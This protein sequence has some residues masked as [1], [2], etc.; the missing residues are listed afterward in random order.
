MGPGHLVGA[1]ARADRCGVDTS[2]ALAMTESRMAG[3]S[4][5]PRFNIVGFTGHRQLEHP[6]RPGE[7]IRAALD[8][9]QGE[10]SGEWIAVSSAA[11]GAD[12]LFARTSLDA[13][14]AWQA[15]L[16]VPADEFREDFAPEDW[17]TVES[18]LERAETVRV[19]PEAESR[20]DAYLDAGM[21][22]V[23]ECDV[24]VAV[25]DGQPS[26][27]KGGTADV[28]TYARE[29]Q[30][31]VVI[32]DPVSG[33]A[34][35]EHFETR[36]AP[37]RELDAFN[38]LREAPA[39]A[40]VIANPFGAPEEIPHFQAKVDHAASRGAPQFRRLTAA[41]VLL[42]V[43]A[44]LAA[45]AELSFVLPGAFLPWVKLLCLLGAVAVALLLRVHGA[46]HHWVRCRLAA[47]FCRSALAT[48]GL[49][50]AAPLFAE[51]DLPGM[52]QLTRS[53]QVLHGR[54]GKG[55]S[56]GMDDFKRLYLTH[57]IED[58]HGYYGRRL[59]RA[60]PL[61]KRLRVGFW[62]TTILAIVCAAWYASAETWPLPAV[63]TA[64]RD[65]VFYF[66]PIALP[67]IAAALLSLV[68]INDLHR[69]VARYREMQSV[70]DG[71]RKQVTYSQTWG[72]LERIVQRTERALLQEVFEWHSITSFAESH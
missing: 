49:P 11:A 70:L 3:P 44:T 58:Q 5:I 60:L 50:R 52:R 23:H 46:H 9:L 31:P 43:M 67:V 18:L 20:N 42:H 63:S 1:D 65:T 29:L 56:T 15:V 45:T 14:L 12:L 41:T 62:I 57:R 59:A 48:W 53:L 32:I 36:P 2:A 26:R 61:L 25:W 27:G 51:L 24:L 39:E 66:L 37:G 33:D 69:R 21:E 55:R 34:R 30:K 4:R 19:I 8:S 13:G 7:A 6:E 16:P 38:R 64:T 71:A 72:S 40:E 54:S 35:R 68:S 28:V 17:R 47:E 22:V 10:N